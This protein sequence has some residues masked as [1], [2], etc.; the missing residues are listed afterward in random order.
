MSEFSNQ[1]GA[2]IDRLSTSVTTSLNIGG[3][4]EGMQ[5]FPHRA[6]KL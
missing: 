5:M 3:G 6:H 2:P 4:T 1:S